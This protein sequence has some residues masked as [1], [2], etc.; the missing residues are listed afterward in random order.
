[1]SIIAHFKIAGIH[2]ALEKTIQVLPGVGRFSIADNFTNY[3]CEL[4][5]L[6]KISLL[7]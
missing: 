4:F 1:M 3:L 6:D 7:T 2:L 5:V